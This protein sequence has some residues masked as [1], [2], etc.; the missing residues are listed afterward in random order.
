M[1]S[2]PPSILEVHVAASLHG[3]RLDNVLSKSTAL[4]RS[5]ASKRIKDGDVTLNAQTVQRPATKVATGDHIYVR[6]PPSLPE[7]IIPEAQD[8]PLT[9]VFED[10]DILVVNKTSDMVIHPSIAHRDG[11]LAHALL[12]YAPEIA[13][14][15]EPHRPGIVHRIDRETSGIVVVAR[16]PRAFDALSEAFARQRPERRYLA[17]AARTHGEGLQDEGTIESLHGRSHSDRRRFTGEH[18][19]RTAITHYRVLERFEQ[20]ALLVECHLQTGRTHQIRMHL[21]ERGVPI[22]GDAL[23]GGGAVERF[24]VISRTALHAASLTLELPWMESRRFEAEPPADFADAIIT[25]RNGPPYS[26]ETVRTT[27]P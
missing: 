16:S 27:K 4:S 22:L 19:R 13:S 17:L 24:R 2:N 3:Q 26:Y 10:E 7:T 18:G 25:L 11:T 1:P 23:Y 12:H 21:R 6:L 15:G 5:Q 20:G 8:L 14:L 9:L